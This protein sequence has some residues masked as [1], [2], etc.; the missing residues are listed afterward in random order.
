MNILL[1]EDDIDTAQPLIES[2]QQSG[3]QC[4]H[5]D[6]GQ[7]GLSQAQ[8]NDYDALIVD[9]MLPGLDGLSVVKTLREDNNLVP[10]LFLTAMT[11]IDDRVDG[12]MAGAD[13][14]LVK[15]FALAELIARLTVIA[16]RQDAHETS[17]IIGD[18]VLNRLTRTVTR[19]EQ[20]ITL[21]TREFE[22]L[23]YLMQHNGQLVT[24]TML[25]EKVWHYHFDPQTN[26]IDVHISRLRSK[27]NI[28]GLPPL[29]HTVRGKGY[30]LHE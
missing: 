8:N 2:L 7:S 13:D 6:N 3:Y 29:L 20:P 21:R 5:A 12:L 4:D 11:D 22:L 9:R 24:R 25:L 1:I 19:N 23:E 17:L 27:L 10:V 26:I 16:R 30:S 15:P 28:D 14:Y 18:L